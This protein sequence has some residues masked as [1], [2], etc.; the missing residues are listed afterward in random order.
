MRGTA[1]IDEPVIAICINQQYPYCSNDSD[2][3]D[4]TRGLWRLN[5][6]RAEKAEYAFAVYQGEI[7]E[8]YEIE[9]WEPATKVRR[10]FWFERLKSQG[11]IINPAEHE[12][13]SDFI[14]KPAS[15][16]IREKYVGKVMPARQRQN[17][18]RYFNC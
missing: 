5:R 7:K 13:R 8:V 3:Y 4:C 10:D 1:R 18:I 14:G 16:H 9:R 11:R 2:L 15:Q 17:P 6:E 12:G